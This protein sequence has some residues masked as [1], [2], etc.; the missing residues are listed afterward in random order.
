[1]KIKC[2][3]TMKNIYFVYWFESQARHSVKFYSRELAEKLYSQLK[4]YVRKQR[5]V[6]HLYLLKVIK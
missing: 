5:T 6:S 1:M 2:L 4:R 3:K